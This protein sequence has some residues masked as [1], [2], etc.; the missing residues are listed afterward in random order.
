MKFSV[1][2]SGVIT[3][4]GSSCSTGQPAALNWFLHDFG[5]DAEL[6]GRDEIDESQLVGLRGIVKIS[7]IVLN[8][9]YL[10]RLDGFA[11]SSRWEELSPGNPYGSQ[12]A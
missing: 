6:L 7:H 3:R 9:T 11:P 8:G 12:V 10:V 1:R 5:Y 4:T 2:L